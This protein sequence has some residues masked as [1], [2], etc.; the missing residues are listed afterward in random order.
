MDC[1]QNS[2]EYK[3]TSGDLTH[4][5]C[6]EHLALSITILSN[7][8][9]KP[10]VNEVKSKR[11]CQIS[12]LANRAL[13]SDIPEFLKSFLR[14]PVIRKT[15]YWAK[16]SSDNPENLPV[17]TDLENT[18]S[19]EDI[20]LITQQSSQFIVV[21]YWLG[22]H[23]CRICGLA[24][25]TTCRTDGVRIWPESMQHYLTKHKVLPPNWYSLT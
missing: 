19:E 8:A 24:A 16:C 6:K 9:A 12:D 7:F 21:T 14:N 23:I 20:L 11:K 2:T 15:A 5:S 18:A 4:F 13:N 1:K 3:L 10:F 17:V 22:H 25:G